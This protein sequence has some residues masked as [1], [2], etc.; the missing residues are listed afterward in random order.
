MSA[1]QADWFLDE[2][3]QFDTGA[4][5]GLPQNQLGLDEEPPAHE[6]AEDG[7]DDDMQGELT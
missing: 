7:Q 4:A 1:Y 2:E 6:W 5:A 3:G